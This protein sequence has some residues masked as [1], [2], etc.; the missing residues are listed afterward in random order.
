MTSENGFPDC[1]FWDFS[2]AVYEKSGVQPACL[3]LQDRHG[4]DVNL[5]LY[6]CWIAACGRGVLS[7]DEL[8]AAAA[9]SAPWHDRIVKGLRAVRQ[10]LK[11]GFPPAPGALAAALRDRIIVIETD[12]E[13][14]EQI[15]L[16]AALPDAPEVSDSAD[17]YPAE[18][19]A[20]L[21]LYLRYRGAAVDDADREDLMAIL[22]ACFPEA[23]RAALATSLEADIS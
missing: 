18:A 10:E 17:R 12:G 23:D 14:V 11:G 20:N 8:A 1:A 2:V 3:G 13:R 16:C 5:L 19:A 4:L 15:M 22:A 21:L 9:L 6:C 7:A